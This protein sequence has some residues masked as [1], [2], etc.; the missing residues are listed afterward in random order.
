MEYNVFT[1]NSYSW[2]DPADEG[3]R[4]AFYWQ[5]FMQARTR[6]VN[7]ETQWEEAAAIAWPEYRNTFTFGHINSPGE[8]KAQWQLDSACAI[9]SHRFGAIAGY[10]VFPNDFIWSEIQFDNDY[11]MKQRNVGLWCEDTTRKLWA[12]RYSP[13]ANFIGQNQQNLQAL[14]VFGNMGM[15][16]EERMT[17]G[18]GL[19]YRACS[20]GE[21]Y[22]LQ[23]FQGLVEGYI[24]AFKLD[25]QQAW[26]KWGKKIPPV[27]RSAL[28]I[29]SK[30]LY[31]FIQIV[32]PRDDWSPWEQL[33]PRGKK[34]CSAYLSVE[35]QCIL[36]DGGY[37]TLPLAIARYMQAPEED[38]GRGPMQMVLPAAK[39]ANS[40]SKDFMKVAHQHGD[41]AWFVG[42]SGLIDPDF[43]SGGINE[44]GFDANGKFLI[45]RAP[46]GELPAIEKA[47]DMQHKFIDDAHLVTLYADLLTDARQGIQRSAREVIERSV[48]KGIFL[49]PLGRLYSEY[50][51]VM[52]DRELDILRIQGKLMPIPDEVKEAKGELKIK[53]NSI[54]GQGAEMAEAAS[55]MQFTEWLLTIANQAQDPGV[56]DVMEMSEAADVVAKGR[57]VPMRVLASSQSRQQKAQGRQQ[58]QQQEMEIKKAPADAAIMKARAIMAKAQSPNPGQGGIGG[59]LSGTPASGMPGVPGNPPG[60]PGLPPRV[61][62]GKG[63]PGRRG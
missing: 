12:A 40:M 19:A 27:L 21:I 32:H 62:G 63:T 60:I 11:L 58:Q 45:E 30:Q 26:H 10:I 6:R 2:G 36:E 54:L 8:K 50:T 3:A 1:P 35:G 13:Y 28:E 25:A 22:I 17:H 5:L 38:Y 37:R 20:P 33:T 47:L 42:D 52:V 43:T 57:R 18:T 31:N 16:T 46:T 4:M 49:S 59:T 23:G 55:V 56:L 29:N 39:S 9:A 34:Y 61:P 53:Y 41:P 24:R 14:G 7:F 15:F 48:E 51:P 44:G